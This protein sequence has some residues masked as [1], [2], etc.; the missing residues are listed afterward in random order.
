[1]LAYFPVYMEER[2]MTL[3]SFIMSGIK[4]CGEMQ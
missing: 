3:L 2:T 4:K 1:M